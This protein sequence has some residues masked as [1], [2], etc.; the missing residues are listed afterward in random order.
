MFSIGALSK[1]AGALGT[2]AVATGALA[3]KAF[4]GLLQTAQSK[5]AETNAAGTGDSANSAGLDEKLGSFR[6]KF[7]R[8]LE[9]YGIDSSQPISLQSDE[10]G[11]LQVAGDHP[12]KD[13]ISKLL[14]DHPELVAEFQSLQQQ[15]TAVRAADPTAANAVA[16]SAASRDILPSST[17]QTF[18]L[19]FQNG[20]AKIA[21]V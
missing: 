17:A 1:S 8:L 9:E 6:E 7:Q 15:A 11:S 16:A 5:A 4:G 12:Q 13:A 3:G 10:W 2:A 19:I 18:N 14:A 20:S 21:F